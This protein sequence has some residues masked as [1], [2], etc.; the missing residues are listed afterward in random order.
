MADGAFGPWGAVLKTLAHFP[1]DFEDAKKKAL[2]Q[3]GQFFRNEILKGIREQAPGGK[4][5]KPLSPATLAFRRY[6]FGMRGTKALI[7]H[8][9]LRNSIVV[10]AIGDE[11]FVGI[12]RTAKGAD[13]QSLVDVAEI[14]E[15]GSKPIVV[16]IT[17]K[18]AAMLH[19]AFREAGGS[20]NR[21]GPPPK[22][23]GI[24]VIQIPARPFLAP[25]FEKH[26]DPEKASARFAERFRK[27]MAG[28]G[29]WDTVR[30]AVVE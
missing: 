17:P 14:Q 6:A 3:E 10:Q 13:G 21:M 2:L 8:G 24:I 9:N 12:L 4:Q 23:T 25:I 5:F 27:A 1:K 7:E 19:Q 30:G 29:V 20:M 26:G 15:K 28:K 16:K 11:V 22:S 18:M